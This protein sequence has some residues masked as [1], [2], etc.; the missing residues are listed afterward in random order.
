MDNKGVK[1]FNDCILAY[2]PIYFRT[3]FSAKAHGEVGEAHHPPNH[4]VELLSVSTQV[5]LH[6]YPSKKIIESFIISTILKL[7]LVLRNNFF[8][9]YISLVV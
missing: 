8:K 1:I 3:R 5:E 4:D 7:Y 6:V 9:Y 2:L